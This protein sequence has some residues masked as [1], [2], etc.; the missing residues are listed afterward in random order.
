[1][2]QLIALI[3]GL[4]VAVTSA[5]FCVLATISWIDIRERRI[6]DIL[7]A[8]LFVAGLVAPDVLGRH[9]LTWGLVSTSLG[10][11]TLWLVRRAYFLLRGRHGLGLGDVKLVGAGAAWIGVEGLPLML[12]VASVLALLFVSLFSLLQRPVLAEGRL[13]FGPFLAVGM[14]FVWIAGP[15]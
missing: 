3:T 7:T 1:M 10:F 9:D 12:L 2:R 14:L 6:P 4:D 8:A 11:A 15:L 13:P 5:L